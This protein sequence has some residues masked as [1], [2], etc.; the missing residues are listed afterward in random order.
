VVFRP[1][2]LFSKQ[3]CFRPLDVKC[4]NRPRFL[5]LIFHVICLLS[6]VPVP[7]SVASRHKSRE[8]R[9]VLL[10]CPATRHFP[11]RVENRV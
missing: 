10:R 8:Y 1:H 7:V 2:E 9:K 11:H 6:Y 4:L 3:M 5:F